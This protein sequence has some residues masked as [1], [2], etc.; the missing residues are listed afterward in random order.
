MEPIVVTASRVAQTADETLASVTVIDREEIEKQQAVSVPDLLRGVPG[1]VVS[2][3]GGPGSPSS[4]FLRGTNS[5]HVLVLIDGVKVGSPTL[6]TTPF[7]HIPVEQIERIEIVRGPRSSLYGSEA[8]G[9]VIQIFTRRGGGEWSPS[10]SLGGGRYDT[11]KGSAA[12]SGGGGNAWFNA[13]LSGVDTQGFNACNGEPGVAGC[14]TREPD[15]DG[16]RNLSG[17]LRAGYR[18]DN[19]TEVDAH[20]LRTEGDTEFD[21]DFQNESETMQQV[22]GAGVQLS[23]TDI[24]ALSLK[25]GR[26]R[27]DSDNFKD[28]VFST[29][30]E[31]ERDT[32]S[33]QNDISVSEDHL[34]TLGLDYQDD[35]VGGS[36]AYPVTSRD[37]NGLFG[38]YLGRLGLHDIQA[39]LRGDDNEQFGS[40]ATGGLAWGYEFA[41]GLRLTAS[42][43]TAFRAPTFNQLYFPPPFPGNPDLRP[44]ESE[45]IE[46]GLKGKA[47]WAGWSLNAYQT[48]L[49][50]L[51]AFDTKTFAPDNIET[52]RIRGLEAVVNAR[53]QDWDFSANL[54]LL[55]PLNRG[56]GPNRDNLLPRRAE[57]SLRLDLDRVFGRFSLGTTL[58]AVGR[59]YDDI[60]NTHELDSYATVDVR[61]EYRLAQAWRI[62][63]RVDNLF[64]EDYETASFYNQS[65]R[66]LFL[67]LRYQP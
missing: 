29:R 44:E 32:V 21:G 48:N 35:R 51:I 25:A 49:D 30:F 37:N 3:S 55:D 14:F 34:L 1:L 17:S 6:G 54:T 27:D 4:M 12:L 42:Y 36:T 41:G 66:S 22:L 7:E 26:S 38:Q 24:W 58:L 8:V 20:W 47:G 31:T 57:W 46:L 62:Q 5:D 60:A 16:Y 23:P 64:D 33:L 56:S 59:R 52:A 10:F 2:N 53:F 61:A 65:G 9:G 43:G 63:A 15:R 67:T 19:G 13:T 28:G 40:H 18:F 50:D 45:S 11:Y 39:S